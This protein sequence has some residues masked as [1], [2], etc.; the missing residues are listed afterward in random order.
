MAQIIKH[1][2]VIIDTPVETVTHQ[3]ESLETW[4]EKDKALYWDQAYHEGYEA[5]VLK[6][7]QSIT[8]ELDDLKEQLMTL[9]V[10][11]PDAI[12]KAR[13]GL[14]SEITAVVTL[15]IQRYFIEQAQDSKALEKQINRLLHEVNQQQNITLYLHPRDIHLLQ[16]GALQLNKTQNPITIKTDEVMALGGFIIKTAHGV[17]DASVERQLSQLKDYLLKLYP[18]ENSQ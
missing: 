6:A 5:G 12:E 2:H 16:T 15:I 3:E 9:V 11:I 10:A 14:S 1:C 13:L 17:F 18:V 8:Q 7:Q 4:T